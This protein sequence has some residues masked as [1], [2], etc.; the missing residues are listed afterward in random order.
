MVTKRQPLRELTYDEQV[1]I[2]RA[3]LERHIA[4]VQAE[5][6][7]VLDAGIDPEA[8]LDAWVR[9]N[10]SREALEA[11]YREF[12]ASRSAFYWDDD[13]DDWVD[14]SREDVDDGVNA[15]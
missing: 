4:E 12:L 3:N 5:R 10:F 9:H 2:A 15:R 11:T 1:A 8:E 6:Q 13:N 14:E 7:R